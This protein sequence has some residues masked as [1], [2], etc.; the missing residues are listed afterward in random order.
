MRVRLRVLTPGTPV[1]IRR[2]GRGE[3]GLW[4][5]GGRVVGSDLDDPAYDLHHQATGPG[6]H[7]TPL[8]AAPDP[9]HQEVSLMPRRPP[10][11]D[12]D[13]VERARAWLDRQHQRAHRQVLRLLCETP[14]EAI[15]QALGQLSTGELWALSHH[16]TTA[17]QQ[18][19]GPSPPEDR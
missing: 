3:R 10:P 12:S 8:A 7:P 1:R 17:T 5:V 15:S 14:A 11:T 19:L 13:A 16:L 9:H 6:A 2:P 4:L 18:W